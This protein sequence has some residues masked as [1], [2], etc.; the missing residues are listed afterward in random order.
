MLPQWINMIRNSFSHGQWKPVCREING[1]LKQTNQYFCCQDIIKNISSKG[2][3]Q[4]KKQN[5]VLMGICGDVW[6]NFR[7]ELNF[8]EGKTIDKIYWGIFTGLIIQ[9]SITVNKAFFR[10][11]KGSKFCSIFPSKSHTHSCTLMTNRGLSIESDSI[12]SAKLDYSK[13]FTSFQGRPD[14]FCLEPSYSFV[15]VHF[16]STKRFSWQAWRMSILEEI[17]H[18]LKGL[19]YLRGTYKLG[20]KIE[21]TQNHSSF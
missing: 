19:L 3:E 1:L 14:I 4:T 5:R 8:Q 17:R 16:S 11:D 21:M 2:I 6:W 20:T 13:G 9:L 7:N 15:R 18:S 12:L 10:D